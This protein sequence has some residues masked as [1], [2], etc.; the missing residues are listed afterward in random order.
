M[1]KAMKLDDLRDRVSEFLST[2]LCSIFSYFIAYVI[3]LLDSDE[4]LV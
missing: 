1:Y 3:R 4:F 2:Q